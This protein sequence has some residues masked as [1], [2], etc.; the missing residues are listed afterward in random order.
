MVWSDFRFAV[1][2]LLKRPGF[3]AVA[4]ATLA[5]GIG[6]N[7]AI[8]SI[9]DA[10]LLRP[11]PYA[12]VDRLVRVRGGSLQTQEFGNLSPMD[13]YDLQARTRTFERLAAFNNYADATLTGA[14]EPERIVGTRV[15]AD[16][17][18]ILHTAPIGGRDFGR[19]DDQPDAPR[20]AILSYGFWTRRFSAGTPSVQASGIIGRTIEL[21]SVPATI[22]GVLPPTFRHPFPDNARQPDVYVPFRLDRRE[23]N[24]GGHYL[25]AIGLLKPGVSFADGQSD[26]ATIAGDLAREYPAT[27]TGRT[28]R[29][30]R[31]LDSMVGETRTALLILA[32]AV[33]FVLLIACGNLANLLLARSQSRRKEIAVRQALGASRAQ[34]VRQFLIESLTLAVAGGACGLIIAAA[35]VR[36]VSTLGADRIPRGDT[37]AVD[38]S[39]MAFT[40]ALSIATGLVFGVGPALHAARGDAHDA[41]GQGGRSVDGQLHQRTQQALVASEMAMALMLLVCAGLLLKSFLRLQRVDPGFQAEQVLTLRTSLPLARYP[42]GEEIPFYRRVEERLS[43]LPGVKRV[44]AINILPLSGDYSCDAFEI[45][46]RPPFPPAQGPCAEARSVT[47]GYFEAMG[48]PLLRGRPFENRDTEDAQHVVI[49]SE[50]MAKRLWPG[51]DPLGARIVYRDV[52]R[53]VVGVVADVKHFGLDRDAPF[54]LYTPHAQQTSYHTMTLVVRTPAS[55]SS[56]LPSIQR[57]LW[58]ID[59]DV[60]ISEVKTMD[61]L[62]A[63]STTEPR[64]RTM[65]VGAFAALA[66]LLSVVGVAGV[67]AYAVTRRTHEIGIRVALGATRRQVVGMMVARGFVPTLIGVAVGIGGAL[68]ITRV[69]SGLLFGVATTDASV[70]I[71][72]TAILT[73]AALVATYVPARRATTIDPM[74]ALR[75]D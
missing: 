74:I 63:E 64:L 36:L 11:L 25:Q 4:V 73:F 10:V 19:D 5:L 41:L 2:A 49:I 71:T 16:F 68:A 48:I 51:G 18:P 67:I 26:L 32:G 55:P 53:A 37:I 52:P 24:R 31:L 59:R 58:S 20:V 28:V 44:G 30:E 72:A 54:E 69:L 6:A 61:A 7:T 39:V 15:T 9:V 46:G 23:N 17:F 40:F 27:D 35:A 56:L 70:F 38:A 50:D 14:G 65:L 43:A 12:N 57:E 62:V 66:V 29:L 3:T 33:A 22:I 60:P 34:L 42:E 47:P 8:F 1:R 45:E 13:F 21:N 75:G